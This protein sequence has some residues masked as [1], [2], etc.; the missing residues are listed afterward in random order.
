MSTPALDA[1]TRAAGRAASQV[2]A[3]YSTSFGAAT[4]LLGA[5]HRRHVRNV[6]ALVRVADE[7]VDG[8]CQEA[9]LAPAEQE[10]ALGRL[11]DET[12]RAV[13]TGFS[14]DLVVHAFANTAR[15]AGIGRDLIDPF[16]ASMR[17]DLR[18]EAGPVRLDERAHDAYVH[19]SAEVVGLIT[20][21]IRL[22]AAA[23]RPGS[24]TR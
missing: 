7:I 10:E 1:Y 12:H 22:A 9:G 16:F 8:V 18:G 6:Y 14:S 23:Q 17:S 24:G 15:E 2:I 5:R 13:D 21:C 20:V 19:G 4:R 3:A 11:V